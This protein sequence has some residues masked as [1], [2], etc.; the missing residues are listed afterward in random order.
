MIKTR[1]ELNV[2]VVAQMVYQ[3]RR[4]KRLRENHVS[5]LH[6]V[7]AIKCDLCQKVAS[8]PTGVNVEVK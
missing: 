6:G 1:E 8:R 5:G 3:S 4:Q 2:R 7:P